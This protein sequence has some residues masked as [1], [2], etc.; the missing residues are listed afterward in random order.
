MNSHTNHGSLGIKRQAAHHSARRPSSRVQKRGLS[1]L[2]LAILATTTVGGILSFAV[3]EA[4]RLDPNYKL[5]QTVVANG[6]VTSMDQKTPGVS[7]WTDDHGDYVKFSNPYTGQRVD[8]DRSDFER[9]KQDQ[10]NSYK[11][12]W[13]GVVAKFKGNSPLNF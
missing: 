2:S 5:A 12:G 11:T 6:R 4:G 8:M 7:P 9:A 13:S 1:G 3:N 10:L